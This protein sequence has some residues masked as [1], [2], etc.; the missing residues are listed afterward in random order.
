MKY[1]LESTPEY[2]KWF[3]K[4]KDALTKTRILAR[5]S[6][7][8]KGDF[9]DYKPLEANL[10]ELRF[11]FGPGWRIYYTIKNDSVVILLVGGEKSSQEKD[12][13]KASEL[14]AEMEE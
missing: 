9:G 3:A 2:D 5:L 1:T 12:I 8:E 10:F 11:F 14:L 13:A 6:R 4:L 7:I